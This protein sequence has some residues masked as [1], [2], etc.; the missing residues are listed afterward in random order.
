MHT[1]ISTGDITFPAGKAAS[2]VITHYH[3]TQS[4]N[5][6]FSN[7]LISLLSNIGLL[8][9]CCVTPHLEITHDTL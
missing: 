4:Y 9:L 3:Y 5:P 8:D 1:I 6:W 7:Q 2:L